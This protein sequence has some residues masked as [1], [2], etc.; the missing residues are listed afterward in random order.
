MLNITIPSV[1]YFDEAKSEF[2]TLD[3]VSLTLEHSLVSISK[4]ESK[5]EKAFLSKD[6]K[7]P[8]ETFA[9]IE[10]MILE[11]SSP[12]YDLKHLGRANVNKINEY[13]NAKQSAT[14]F[15]DLPGKKASGRGTVITA[16]LVYYWMVAH[17]IP[18]ECQYWHINRLFTLIKICNEK[19]KPPK[20]MSNREVMSQHKALNAQRR[21]AASGG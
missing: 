20:K 21:A 3:E 13:I 14:W 8:E 2:V 6:E 19:N 5:F 9:Y 11:S 16:E 1:D 10:N 4:W 7:T 17:Q 18:F 12:T 15:T